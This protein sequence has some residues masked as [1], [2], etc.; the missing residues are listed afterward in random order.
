MAQL[1]LLSLALPSSRALRPSKSRRFTSLP[2]D[3]PTTVAGTVDRQHDFR[4]GIVPGRIGADAD[5][6]A[7]A[8]GGHGLRFVEDF[9]VGADAD[10]QVLG[11]KVAPDQRFL[12]A[13]CFGEP[14]LTDFRFGAD[15][16]RRWCGGFL[17][18]SAGLPLA[19][20]SITRSSMLD[21]E[22]HAA[23][24]QRLQVAGRKQVGLV[25]IAPVRMRIGDQSRQG[26]RSARAQPDFIDFPR[27][28]HRVTAVE[29]LADSR[30]DARQIVNLPYRRSPPGWARRTASGGT[31]AR[32]TKV[33]RSAS[34]GRICAAEISMCP[35]LGL[36][37]LLIRNRYSGAHSGAHST[38]QPSRSER[39]PK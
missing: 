37:D 38:T 26:R 13:H 5:L 18:L 2:S 15:L 21:D 29:Q 31:Q 8:D 11:P 16:P 9:G 39:K 28:S 3:A 35:P 36:F 6:C 4:L 10:F 14:G 25:R 27:Q 34:A 22:S 20:S 17:R 24:A 33:A 19:C 32:P 7:H 30:H 23:G 1:A 12:E